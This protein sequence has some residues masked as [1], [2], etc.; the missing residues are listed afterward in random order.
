VGTAIDILIISDDVV[1]EKMAGPGIR[2]WELARSLSRKFKV[3]LVVPDYSPGAEFFRKAPF[4][5]AFY[6]VGAPSSVKDL[7]EQSRLILF[8]GY[9]LSKFP[10]LKTIGRPLIADI[11]DPFVL[12]NLF[13]HQLKVTDIADRESIHLRDLRVFNDI[14]LHAAHFVCASERQK[15]LFMGS[16]MSLNRITPRTL[17][18]GPDLEDLIS[19]V[20]FGIEDEDIDVLFEKDS[21]QD[22]QPKKIIGAARHT[23]SIS[24][25][26]DAGTNPEDFHLVPPP[27]PPPPASDQPTACAMLQPDSALGFN[28]FGQLFPQIEP[29]DILLLWGGVITN[30]Y[31]PLS[32]LRAFA[33][34]V[35]EAPELRLKL[36]F[37]STTHPNPLVPAFEMAEEARRLAAEL[38]LLGESVFFHDGW[39]DY[40]RR[41]AFFRR[42]DIGVSIHKTHFEMR[43]AFRTRMLDYI[44]YG[45]PIVCTEGD[46]FAGLVAREGLGAAVASEDVAGLKNAILD[47]ARS[48]ASRAAIKE[49]LDI[50]KPQ[51]FWDRATAPLVAY[52]RKLISGALLPALPPRLKDVV[53][54]CSG[55]PASPI[56]EGLKRL[57]WKTIQTSPSKMPAKIRRRLKF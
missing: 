54:V 17:D 38:K 12:E 28:T 25:E 7:A 53:F 11:Y 9:V 16:L 55:K 31:D 56:R 26:A 45:L 49:K 41:G 40:D 32:L 21:L 47:L 20:P 22:N 27:L 15:D 39:I 57:F 33:A 43:F 50:L 1:G 34:A 14:V 30:W 8:Q 24:Q 36:L 6:S 29:A 52:C 13:V 44:K 46:Y 48:P 2:A 18:A 23:D 19:V 10:V 51:F 4:Q 37:L 3:V 35:R 5:V 42:A